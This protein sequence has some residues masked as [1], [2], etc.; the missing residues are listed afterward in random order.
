MTPVM[1]EDNVEHVDFAWYRKLKE[2]FD[3]VYQILPLAL[4]AERRG[5]EVTS[6][7]LQY[8]MF[9][10]IRS[11]RPDLN[12]KEILARLPPDKRKKLV[13]HENQS[14]LDLQLLRARLEVWAKDD[15]AIR[16]L[17]DR[18]APDADEQDR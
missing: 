11:V 18:F 14:V 13:W 1:A 17:L 8:E 4:E 9:A 3:R 16:A 10:L 2:T 6:L 7:P 12:F 5:D 15:P